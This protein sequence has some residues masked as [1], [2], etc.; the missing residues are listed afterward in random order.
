MRFRPFSLFC[1]SLHP[2]LTTETGTVYKKWANRLPIALLYPNIYSVAVS[3]L[4]FQIVYNLLNQYEDI[5][6][7]RF[8]YPEA[9][10]PFRSLE[11]GRALK[12]FPLICGS[13]SFEDDFPRL[14]AMLPAGRIEPYAA[15]RKGR[16]R[17]GTPLVILGGV[18]VM[19]NPEPLAPFADLMIIGEAEGI[20]SDLVTLLQEHLTAERNDLLLAAAQTLRGSY[21]PAL[22]TFT[23]DNQG[24]VTEVDVP[25]GIPERIPKVTAPPPLRAG[26]S[27]LLSP[28]AELNMYMVELGRGCSR[29]CRFCAAG[30]IYRP[31]RLWLGEA[32]LAAV[33]ERPQ[34]VA[35]VGMLG[36]EMAH[37]STLDALASHLQ[38]S[39]CSLSFS[40]LRADHISDS[41]LSLLAAS[42]LKSVAIAPDGSSERLRRVINKGL[43]EEDLVAAAVRLAGAGIY[44]L[45][46]YIMIGLPTE[47]NEDL[48]E[49][50][51]LIQRIQTELLAI[52]RER[53]RLT[54]LTLSVNSFVPKPWTPFQYC[55]YGG[56]SSV[57]AKEDTTHRK[58]VM[59]LKEKI[60]YLRKALRLIPNVRIN[61]DRPERVLHQAVFARADRR[62][63]PLLLDLGM[64]RLSFT[65]AAQRHNLSPWQY[66]VR[67]R[68]EGERM[69]WEI[70]DHGLKP[71]YLWKEYAKSMAGQVTPP[72]E[73]TVCRR[74]GI[75]NQNTPS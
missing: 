31:P 44:H 63:A 47:T 55:S 49:L 48:A 33:E 5:V 75:C 37:P 38:T 3:N 7:E 6:C 25:S 12:E 10:A 58:A 72:C 11:S 52:G 46:L 18:A 56:L 53:G 8:V 64:G 29:G 28:D 66:A 34:G 65:Q 35:R 9:G 50:A 41:L 23:Y 68:E 67:P 1:I 71:G 32:V 16:V 36:M 27:H 40:S 39:N 73:T 19:M 15:D 20:V 24:R 14:A 57:Q 2:S 61:V 43:C 21:V 4:G 59:A 60:K 51:D 13:V 69:C 30:Y 17:A 42:N 26:H 70:I 45:K 62:I 22:Y 74:C 54:E